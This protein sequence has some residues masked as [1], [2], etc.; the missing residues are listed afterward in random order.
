[1]HA[2]PFDTKWKAGLLEMSE[3]AHEQQALSSPQD[4]STFN[5]SPA[6]WEL[7]FLFAS[8]H[9]CTPFQ[10]SPKGPQEMKNTPVS[11][12]P[13]DPGFSLQLIVV[14]LCEN[15]FFMAMLWLWGY[16]LQGCLTGWLPRILISRSPKEK[17]RIN[18]S[19]CSSFCHCQSN[20]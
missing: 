18:S 3:A 16:F 9:G 14:M 17:K 2:K 13:A 10:T 15:A 5:F 11:R 6:V 4:C 20:D 12:H 19:P 7:P 1:M 8:P